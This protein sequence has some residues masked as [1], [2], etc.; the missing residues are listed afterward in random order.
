[1]HHNFAFE[2]CTLRAKFSFFYVASFFFIWFTF[3]FWY[4]W[5]WKFLFCFQNPQGNTVWLESII[6]VPA[7]SFTG[8]FLDTERVNGLSDYAT[9]CGLN[10]YYISPEEE[11]FCRAAIVSL[12]SDFNGGALECECNMDGSSDHSCAKIG[13]Q[14]KCKENIMGRQCTRCK[15]GFFG[16]P[17]C[18]ECNCPPTATCNEETGKEITVQNN[19]GK[20]LLCIPTFQF[21]RWMYLCTPCDW[22]RG[23]SL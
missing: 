14:C 19:V 3:S 15:P 16:Y 4:S 21:S 17:E 5:K 18:K 8:D 10:D 13:G 1:M 20:V 6:A 2:L 23:E 7:E 9:Q 11:G 12:G 22:N